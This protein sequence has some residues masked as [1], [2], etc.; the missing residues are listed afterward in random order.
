MHLGK[1]ARLPALSV[2]PQ[3]TF[4]EAKQLFADAHPGEQGKRALHEP[5]S[6]LRRKNGW[7]SIL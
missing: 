4:A 5:T 6:R 3:L 7:V 1:D 2:F